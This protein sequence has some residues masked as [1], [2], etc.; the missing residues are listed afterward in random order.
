MC[1]QGIRADAPRPAHVRDDRRHPD[2][3]ARAVRL[4]DQHRPEVPAHGGRRR[5]PQPV[6]A[7]PRARPCQNTGYFRVV[8]RARRGERGAT[9]C[10]SAA[11]CSSC[12]RARRISRAALQRGERPVLLVEA[13]ATDPAATGNALAAL[14]RRSARRRSQH[15][16]TGPL[17]RLAPA[18]APFEV[19]VHRRYNPEGITQYNIVPG[20]IGVILHHDDGD[21]DGARDHPRAR[22]RHDGEPARH[23]G[24][25]AR[26]DGGQDRALHPRRLRA[27]RRDPRSRRSSCSTCRW[28]AA[29]ALLLGVDDR[30][31]SPPT[32]R[33][34]S[35]SPRSRAT[36]CR[37]CR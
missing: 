28:S 10:S 18:A 35:R 27:G 26:G 31:S 2:P 5:R 12:R 32:S 23:A 34:A 16:L 33:S 13:D 21:D 15:D 29:S 3:A 7:Q 8:G 24:A 37:R 1:A 4:R 14:D 25:A 11:T 30:S 17:A 36:S 20:L 9:G 6:L 19:R 22:A